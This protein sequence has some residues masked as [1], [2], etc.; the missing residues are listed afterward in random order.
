MKEKKRILL[1]LF[2]KK[3]NM[4]LLGILFFLLFFMLVSVSIYNTSRDTISAIERTYGTSFSIGLT[5][6]K[7]DMNQWED[8][9]IEGMDSPV[10]TYIGPNVDEA[11]VRRITEEVEGITDYEAGSRADVMLYEYELVP[12]YHAWSYNYFT[13]HEHHLPY[14][15]EETKN[16]MY[17]TYTYHTRN[18]CHF[19]QFY[20]GAFRLTQGRH[21]TP[22][23]AFKCIISENFAKRN[24]LKLGDTLKIDLHSLNVRAK[25][26][27]ESLGSVETEI[28]GFFELTYQQTVTQYTEEIDILENWVITDNEAGRALDEIIGRPYYLSAS[29]FFVENPAELDEVMEQVRQ[30]DW[31]DWKYYELV[32]DDGLYSQAVKPLR[33]LKIIMAVC[34]V[35]IVTSGVLL[36]MLVILHSMKRR[37]REAGILMSLG[38]TGKEIRKQF[39]GEHLA[40]G[41]TAFFFAL[42]VSLA[43]TP[44]IG[45]QIYGA[46]NKGGEQ[47]VYTEKEIEAAIA[48]GENSKV[49]E[50]SRN[51]RTGVEPPKELTTRVEVKTALLVFAMMLLIVYYSVNEAIKK[52][53][54]LEPIRVLSMIE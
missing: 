9:A 32:K 52:T 13:T 49:A 27:I 54:K 25:Y 1:S 2:R 15:P 43:V 19:D 21:I 6:D 50:M 33:T 46:V 18:S 5:P 44:G 4:F 28:V 24:H 40:L 29:Q 37:K 20:N 31:I 35:V 17:I 39:L 38:I 53:L 10:R 41:L 22:D 26:P 42:I 34:L 30:L 8:R 11:M 12:G 3:S 48:R 23:D 7:N 16:M 36:L 14:D 45:N 51:Q 47:K